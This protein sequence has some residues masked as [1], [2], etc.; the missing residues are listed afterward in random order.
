MKKIKVL[1]VDDS[2]FM[3][4]VLEDILR[5]DDEIDVVGTA[6]D[7]KEAVELVKRL[8]PDV[9]TMDVEMP[10]MNG[11]DATKT[12]ME[13]KPT[14]IVMLSAITKEGSYNFV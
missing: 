11:L 2:A 12:I 4:K 3:R 9:I 6:K 8:D 1:I 7:G 14:P 5:T 13:V 10:L